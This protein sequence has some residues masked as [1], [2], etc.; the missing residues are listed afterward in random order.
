MVM[1][2]YHL[3]RFCIVVLHRIPETPLKKIQEYN[4]FRHSTYT[5]TQSTEDLTKLTEDT[6]TSTPNSPPAKTAR[7][8]QNTDKHHQTGLLTVEINYDK[9]NNDDNAANS[10]KR[11]HKLLDDVKVDA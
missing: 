3:H 5:P 6:R 4:N 2:V 1:H 10:G 11:A 7:V 9:T 8:S